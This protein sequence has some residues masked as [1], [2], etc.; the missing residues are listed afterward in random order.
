MAED[1]RQDARS[2]NWTLL[3]G[4]GHDVLVEIARNPDA[5]IRDLSV[6]A[7][8][9]ERSVQLIVADLETAGYLTRHRKGR[10]STYVID[11]ASAFRH[12]SQD[13]LQ[14][15]PFL[16]YLVSSSALNED[17][18]ESGAHQ[19]REARSR[20]RQATSAR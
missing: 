17:G 5:R 20:P 19:I 8:I 7:G 18:A 9:T 6:R 11:T 10:R 13:G 1:D 15:G 12:P 4:H 14:V 16:E 3:T 2:R